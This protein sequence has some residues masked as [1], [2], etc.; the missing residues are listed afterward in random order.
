MSESHQIEQ[1]NVENPPYDNS[2]N[3]DIN[4][5]NSMSDD[6]GDSNDNIIFEHESSYLGNKKKNLNNKYC[7]IRANSELSII[8]NIILSAIGG[9]FFTLPYTMYE[10]GVIASLL[11]FLFVTVCIAYSM[12][13]LRSFVVDTKY[14]SFALMTETILGHKWL[15]IYAF[16][17]F[18]IYVGMEVNYLNLIYDKIQNLFQI[19][20]NDILC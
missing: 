7:G 16:S 13:L 4:K 10:G 15:K 9:G 17:S 2:R 5:M 18:I 20:K 8:L 1:F 14:F 12:D 19:E 6:D 3:S 11:V